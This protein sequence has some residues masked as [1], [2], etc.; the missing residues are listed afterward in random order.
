MTSAPKI[1]MITLGCAKNRV[2]TE[3]VLGVLH[4][5]GCR[6]ST[7]GPADVVVINT[8]GFIEAAKQE[9][10]DAILHAIERK[11]QGHVRKVVVA[12]CLAQRYASELAQELADVDAFVGTGRTEA[13]AEAVSD[14]L[15][16]KHGLI[17]VLAQPRHTWSASLRRVQTT[18][19]WTAYLKISEGCNHPCTF[20]AIPA[21]RGPHVSKPLDRVVAE[22]EHLARCGVKELV[23]V[24]QD[25]TQY[26]YDLAGRAL[27]PDLLAALS[28]VADIEWIRLMYCYPSRVQSAIIDALA[29]TPK[30]CAYVDMPLQHAADDVLRGMRRPMNAQGYR[31]ILHD[32]RR[33]LPDVAIRS[34][35]IVGFPGETP[36]HFHQLEEFLRTA[37]FDH[38]GVFEYSR[39]EG[40][41]ASSLPGQV[42]ARVR[43]ARWE[44]LMRVQQ[45]VSLEQ[46]RKWIGR[47]L[48]VLVEE[49]VEG[50]DGR[51]GVGRSFRDAPE[52]DGR[53]LIHGTHAQPGEFVWAR[54][55]DAQPYDLTALE[56]SNTDPAGTGS[57]E[58]LPTSADAIAEEHRVYCNQT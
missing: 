26:G 45:A 36:E 6:I 54:I 48:R 41:P 10:I 18:P 7:H 47:S 37:Q 2:D 34:T 28:Q 58:V 11:K 44:R 55:T 13:V 52:V 29:T 50:V 15:N 30:V 40:T 43:H 9:S 53:V 19:P 35:F 5:S 12:G 22:A 24:G 42:P 31:R 14:V 3:E 32:L 49:I 17:R 38:V 39:E 46:N 56:L 4:E 20:C 57:A 21:I 8:C 27:L 33:A 16:G 51:I 25:T 23:L 1:E